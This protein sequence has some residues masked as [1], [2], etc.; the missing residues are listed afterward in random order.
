MR[1]IVHLVAV[2]DKTEFT[3]RGLDRAL[4]DTLDQPFGL[5]AI[6]NQVGDRTDLEPV[7]TREFGQVGQPRHRSVV[8]QDLAQDSGGRMAGEPRQITARLG[9]A[10]AHEHPALLGDQ[11]KDMSGMH[12]V[13]RLRVGSARDPDRVRAVRRGDARGHAM[14]GLDRYGEVRA[15]HRAV[16]SRHRRQ[17]ELP[18]SRFGDRHADQATTIF[19]HEIDRLG[20]DAIR[21]HDQIALVLAVLFVDEDRHA[22]GLELR[23]D[24][25][26]GA[27]GARR[28]GRS[29]GKRVARVDSMQM[30]RSHGIPGAAGQAIIISR[31][32]GSFW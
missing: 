27:H 16:D 19:G 20:R 23:D 10:G 13:G 30:R 22:A 2:G 28:R 3:L 8:L 29:G 9:V 14:R 17:V 4:T 7:Q 15:V 31:R 1:R 6:V 32:P 5:A 24:L 25:G 11:R 21:G 18:R 12:D 26:S